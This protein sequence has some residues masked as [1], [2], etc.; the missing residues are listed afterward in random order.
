MSGKQEKRARKAEKP[1]PEL[2]VLVK[3]T[4]SQIRLLDTLLERYPLNGQTNVLLP[5]II[6]IGEIR[7]SLLR[8]LPKP[9]ADN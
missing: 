3:L 8:A 7:A 2:P 5:V 6:K 1:M 9:K 4:P